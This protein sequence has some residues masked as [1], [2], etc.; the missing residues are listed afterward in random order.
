MS[1]QPHSAEQ[2]LQ[3]TAVRAPHGDSVRKP[4]DDQVG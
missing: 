1:T 3:P 2:A 4:D